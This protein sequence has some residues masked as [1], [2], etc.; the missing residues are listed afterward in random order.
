[1][2]IQDLVR[3]NP[4]DFHIFRI[5]YFIFGKFAF[6]DSLSLSEVP[7]QRQISVSKVEDSHLLQTF[8]SLLKL[9]DF[10]DALGPIGNPRNSLRVY[11]GPYTEKNDQ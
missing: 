7:I 2:N 8:N 11:S 3:K 4:W 9:F 10:Q 5:L 6:L 1:M